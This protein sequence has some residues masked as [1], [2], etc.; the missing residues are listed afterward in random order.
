[1][2]SQRKLPKPQT[3]TFESSNIITNTHKVA[4]MNESV[5]QIVA[6]R[7]HQTQTKVQEYEKVKIT[8]LHITQ[9]NVLFLMYFFA[10]IYKYISQTYRNSSY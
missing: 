2:V 4:N 1:L 3:L 9:W 8:N 5:W 6:N 10:L 7:K